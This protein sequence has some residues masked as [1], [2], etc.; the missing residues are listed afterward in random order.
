[1]GGVPPPFETLRICTSTY[2]MKLKLLVVRLD[3]LL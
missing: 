2:D 1:M 3:I